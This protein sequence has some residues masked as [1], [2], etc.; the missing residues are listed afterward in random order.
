MLHKILSSNNNKTNQLNSKPKASKRKNNDEAKLNDVEN[1]KVIKKFGF[2][3]M[4][5]ISFLV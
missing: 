3:E 2:S 1:R 4:T 5:Q